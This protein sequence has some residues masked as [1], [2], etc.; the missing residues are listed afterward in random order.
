MFRPARLLGLVVLLAAFD[1]TAAPVVLWDQSPDTIGGTLG[2]LGT[3]HNIAGQQNFA[4]H[5]RFDDAV[6]VSGMDLYM[7]PG[8]GAGITPGTAGVMRVR[9]DAPGNAPLVQAT[10]IA[11]VDT[12]G[13]ASDGNLVRVHVDFGTPLALDAARDY[14]LGLSSAA[15]FWFIAPFTG[16]SGTPLLDDRVSLYS[17]LTYQN[18][19]ALGD[20]AFRLWGTT[21]V[22]LPAPLLP[23]V[24]ALVALRRT[25]RRTTA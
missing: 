9:A 8:F 20:M 2:G 17:G 12:D 14:W 22:P 11:T 23:T 1:V 3:Y 18:E 5:V 21:A 7:N 19:V 10:T 6:L 24:I 13:T 4:E 16:A 15:T 25:R